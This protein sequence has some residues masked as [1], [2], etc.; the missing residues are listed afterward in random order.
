MKKKTAYALASVLA[1]GMLSA[2]TVSAHG[3]FG[4]GEAITSPEE[5]AARHET[6]FREQANVIGVDESEIKEAWASGKTLFDLAKEKGLSEEEIRSRMQ[7]A[8]KEQMQNRLQAL[9]QGG[10]ITQDQ[11]DRKIKTM[12]EWH[13]SFQGKKMFER[14]GRGAFRQLGL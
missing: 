7:E 11:A 2:G 9:V 12:E 14:E 4:G 3:W 6:M 10:V 8:R 5:F 13:S 1:L